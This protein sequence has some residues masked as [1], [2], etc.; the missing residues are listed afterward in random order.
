MKDPKHANNQESQQFLH[1]AETLIEGDPSG[2]ASPA[3]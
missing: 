2:R 3:P 1:E